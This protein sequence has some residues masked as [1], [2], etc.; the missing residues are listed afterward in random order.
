MLTIP[1]NIDDISKDEI[2]NVIDL[3]EQ[4]M[5]ALVKKGD[6]IKTQQGNL[7]IGKLIDIYNSK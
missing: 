1:K 7:I 6:T 2:K 3:C 5:N 4:R